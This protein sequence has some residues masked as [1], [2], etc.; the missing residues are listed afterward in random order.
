MGF[1]AKSECATS[2]SRQDIQYL[3]AAF[4]IRQDMYPLL[5]KGYRG[6]GD[7]I[8]VARLVKCFC[9]KGYLQRVINL[10]AVFFLK[11]CCLEK[12]RKYV[13][14][15]KNLRLLSGRVKS[16]VIRRKRSASG[17]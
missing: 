12:F 9:L 2:E 16:E 17:Y 10:N 6:C 13:D 11:S 7:K 4:N 14:P 3:S 15:D 8:S 1:L 5:Q